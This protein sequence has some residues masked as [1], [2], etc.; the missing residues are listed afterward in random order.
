MSQ[1]TISRSDAALKADETL[2]ADL[3]D[4]ERQFEAIKSEA[5]ELWEG[6]TDAQFNWRSEPGRWSIGECLAHLNVTGQVY[7]PVIDRRIREARAA[8]RTSP[9]PYRYSF[10]GKLIVRG[11]EPPAKI[12]FKAPKIFA[13]QPEHLLSSVGP[14]FI[15]LQ[16]QLIKQLRAA[17]GLDLGGVRITSPASKL[18]KVSLGQIFLLTAAHE[19]RHLYQARQLKA[20]PAFPR[21]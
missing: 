17:N 14:A 15:T 2:A 5:R 3:Q 9:G 7:L 21:P 4:Y 1:Q 10:F 6:M 18:L 8:G 12:K 16:E 19:R 20:D 13:P 11:I